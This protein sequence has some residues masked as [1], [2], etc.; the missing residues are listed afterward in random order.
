MWFSYADDKTILFIHN[1]VHNHEKR[2]EQG[3]IF[4]TRWFENNF[5]KAYSEQLQAIAICVGERAYEGID[6]FEVQGIKIKCEENVT[7]FGINIAY[8]LKMDNMFLKFIK[9]HQHI[10]LF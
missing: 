3:R 10:G 5:I 9:R 8:M 6:S 2:L 1:D 7:L 4:L